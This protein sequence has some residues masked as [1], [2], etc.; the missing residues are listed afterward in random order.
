MHSE[1]GLADSMW[2]LALFPLPFLHP[3]I[4]LLHLLHI[5]LLLLLRRPP[6]IIPPALFICAATALGRG[7][8]GGIARLQKLVGADR[9]YKRKMALESGLC[10]TTH[11]PSH[12]VDFGIGS[13]L[14]ATT[15]ASFAQ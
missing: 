8:R 9:S 3:S 12:A 10:A 6:L 5:L 14:C 1:Q 15:H 13:G 11:A 4:P 2:D 7:L